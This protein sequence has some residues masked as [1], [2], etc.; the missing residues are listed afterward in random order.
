MVRS[1]LV[2][3]LASLCITPVAGVVIPGWSIDGGCLLDTQPGVCILVYIPT[4]GGSADRGHSTALTTTGT[5]T[6]T[7]TTAQTQ[8]ETAQ[9]RVRDNSVEVE[10]EQQQR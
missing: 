2:D 10:T 5:A 1:P 9:H 8:T 4:D 7:T 6:T 3:G